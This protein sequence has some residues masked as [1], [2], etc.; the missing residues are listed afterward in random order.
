M[1]TSPE[2]LYNL[3]PA[4]Y[5]ERDAAEGYP[6]RALIGIIASQALLVE[7]DIEQLY[8]DLFIETCES[9][10]IPYIGDLVSNN[11]LYDFSRNRAPDTAHGLFPD[12]RGRDQIGRASC[13][14][15]V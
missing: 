2:K 14:E 9:W 12:L 7:E 11:P 1:A 8:N 3:L 5:R 4:V 15:R 13:R 10:V 6:L